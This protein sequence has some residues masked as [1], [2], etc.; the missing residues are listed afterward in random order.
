MRRGR[1]LLDPN[2][3]STDG[4]VAVGAIT[5]SEDGTLL[6]YATSAGGLGLADLAGP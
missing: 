4:T 5:V 6:A 2:A 3:L 1:L